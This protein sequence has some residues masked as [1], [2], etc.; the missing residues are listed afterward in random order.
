MAG[1]LAVLLD[2]P[3]LPTGGRIAELRLE[4]KMADHG[5]EPCV[6]L[7]VLAAPDL[8]DR[9]AHVVVDAS[10]G[11]AAQHPESVGM[12][13]EKHLVGLLRVGPEEEG[14]A[15]G[16]VEVSD[17]QLGPLAGNDRPIL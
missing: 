4:Q 2:L 7:A 15:A 1:V 13:I 10:P 3:L 8:V 5:S 6:D 17:L 16:Q 11:N 12:G 14:A 9:G